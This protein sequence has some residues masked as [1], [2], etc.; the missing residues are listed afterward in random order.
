M[1]Y[2]VTKGNFSSGFHFGIHFGR[3]SQTYR[4]RFD[5]S[6]LYDDLDWERDYNK[7]IGWSLSNLPFYFKSEKKWQPGHHRN[8]VRFEWRANKTTGKIQLA[9]YY[10]QDGIRNTTDWIE[11]PVNQ[12]LVVSLSLKDD[13]GV[14]ARIIATCTCVESNISEVKTVSLPHPFKAIWS[15]KLF[16]YFGGSNPAPHNLNLQVTEL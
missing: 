13:D 5:S 9:I 1:K 3:V 12:D 8:S 15:Y 7:L 10:Y 14:N 11:V 6:C 2:N 4:V 16:P